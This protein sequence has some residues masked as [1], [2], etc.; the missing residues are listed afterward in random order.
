MNFRQLEAFVNVIKYRSFSKAAEAI[1]ISQPTVSVHMASL[2][3]ELGVP[4]IIR[5]PK[6]IIPTEAGKIFYNYAMQIIKLRDKSVEEIKKYS[7]KICGSLEIASSTVPA[8]YII[9]HVLA[10]LY[11]D[12][13]DV[14]VTL[15]QF[16]T[17]AVIEKIENMEIEVG[18][19]GSKYE[20]SNCNFIPFME[21]E[22]LLITPNT[23][24]YKNINDNN[25]ID[26]LKNHA[27]IAREKGSGT[28]TETENCLNKAGITLKESNI[29][30]QMDS[31]ESIVQAVKNGL[32]ISIISKHC[33]EDYIDFGKILCHKIPGCKMERTFYIVTRKNRPLSNQA[34]IFIKNMLNYKS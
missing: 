4:L 9:P 20:K 1:F 22:L 13:P 19:C 14:T 17:A 25:I 10:K 11:T 15:R 3:E 8:Q 5:A 12:Y 18:I 28:R 26:L 7:D 23:E 29:T 30:V 2:E 27:F 16:D 34:E 24:K 6:G 32:G 31:S 21:D 33:V